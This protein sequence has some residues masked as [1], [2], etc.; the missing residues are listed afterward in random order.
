MFGMGTGGTPAVWSPTSLSRA[1]PRA[2]AVSFELLFELSAF[3]VSVS[4]QLSGR[5]WLGGGRELRLMC[6]EANGFKDPEDECPTTEQHWVRAAG[7]EADGPLFR[8]N[9]AE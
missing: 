5:A 4:A 1:D 7:P 2:P 9:C 3:R 8:K 6:S